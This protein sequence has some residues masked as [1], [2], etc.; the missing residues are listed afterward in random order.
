MGLTEKR[1]VKDFQDKLFPD[2]K[3]KIDEIVGMEVAVEV[4][5]DSLAKEG[6]SH[7]YNDSYPKV[8]FEPIIKGLG[9]ICADDMGKEAVKSSL[10]KI[11]LCNKSGKYS[12]ASAISFTDGVLTIDHEPTSN[13]ADIDDRKKVVVDLISKSL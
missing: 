9:E 3:K 7:L 11:V 13:V 6:M 5:W 1:A 2:L 10:K 12:P 4:D 8:Y